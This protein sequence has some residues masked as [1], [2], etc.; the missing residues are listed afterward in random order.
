MNHPGPVFLSGYDLYP[1]WRSD[2]KL[3]QYWLSFIDVMY[4]INDKQSIIELALLNEIPIENFF[5]WTDAFCLKNLAS[6]KPHV[7]NKK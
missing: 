3:E 5:Y 7:I 1:D 4:G 6:Q 2:P